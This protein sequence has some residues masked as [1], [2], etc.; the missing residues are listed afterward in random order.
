MRYFTVSF[1]RKEKMAENAIIVSVSFIGTAG[2]FGIPTVTRIV[3][4]AKLRVIE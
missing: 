1:R 2:R 4:I 3:A